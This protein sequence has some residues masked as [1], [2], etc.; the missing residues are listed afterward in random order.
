MLKKYL[1]LQ[2]KL[3]NV[4][5]KLGVYDYLDTIF[6]G[7]ITLPCSAKRVHASGRKQFTVLVQNLKYEGPHTQQQPLRATVMPTTE[8]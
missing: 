5:F 8:I 4:I 2:Q 1:D 3:E 7:F 6:W